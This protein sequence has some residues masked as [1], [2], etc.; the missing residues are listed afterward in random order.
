MTFREVVLSI[1]GLHN[2]D[3]FYHDLLRRATLI[4]GCSGFAGKEIAKKFD[5]FWPSGDQPGKETIRERALARLKEFKVKE[6]Q[7][8]DEIKVKEIIDGR[9][10][11][12]SSRR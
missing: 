10:S 5:K 3:K 9:R 4:I 6:Q 12:D 7:Q 11:E 2:K 1:E 8:R